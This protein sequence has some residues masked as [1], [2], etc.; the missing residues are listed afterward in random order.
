MKRILYIFVALFTVICLAGCDY[1]Y[2][3]EFQTAIDS[4]ENTNYTL[5][6]YG[7]TTHVTTYM[8]E[9]EE[10]HFDEHHIILREGKRELNYIDFGRFNQT[11][12]LE[13]HKNEIDTYSLDND[14]WEFLGTATVEDS[15]SVFT[16]INPEEF[17][18]D[19]FICV[20]E[21]KWVPLTNKYDERISDFLYNNFISR[22]QEPYTFYNNDVEGFTVFVL[23]GSIARIEFTFSST[24][25]TEQGKL[26]VVSYYVFE[27]SNIGETDV[28]KPN[29]SK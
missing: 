25:K 15:T 27:Y 14:I 3:D 9:V 12:Y 18:H 13:K 28:V 1:E 11:F 8:G 20:S 10:E 4:F 26:D 23:N 16:M 2:K 22:N 24:F 7:D 5:N 21:G 29:V 19:D 17:C 6:V